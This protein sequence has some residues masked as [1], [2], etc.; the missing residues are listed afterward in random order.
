MKFVISR[1]SYSYDTERAPHPDAKLED[2]AGVKRWTID[3]ASLEALLAL[4]AGEMVIAAP[5]ERHPL[6]M[7]EIYDD[8]RE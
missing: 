4:D 5:D 1:T 7:V 6:P 3:V 8:Y 2:V